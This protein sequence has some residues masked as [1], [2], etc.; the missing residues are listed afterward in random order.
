MKQEKISFVWLPQFTKQW[1]KYLLLLKY[2]NVDDEQDH[3]ENK[4][5]QSNGDQNQNNFLRV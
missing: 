2:T 5:A 1:Q 3:T 4:D